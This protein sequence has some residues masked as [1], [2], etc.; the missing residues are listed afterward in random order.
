M[1]ELPSGATVRIA[2]TWVGPALEVR[3]PGICQWCDV[4]T[5]AVSPLT[6]DHMEAHRAFHAFGRV[7][8]AEILA[9]QVAAMARAIR[10]VERRLTRA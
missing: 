5:A 4:P 10:W 2:A 6:Q 1:S 9:P 8:D 3:V 7:I